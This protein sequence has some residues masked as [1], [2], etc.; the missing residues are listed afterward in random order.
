MAYLFLLIKHK[1]YAIW[2]NK[3]SGKTSNLKKQAISKNKQ[4]QKI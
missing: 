2:K 3:Q 4:S 1:I